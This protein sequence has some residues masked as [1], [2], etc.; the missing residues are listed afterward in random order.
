MPN[1][2]MSKI[3]ALPVSEPLEK[4]VSKWLVKFCSIFSKELTPL[5][6]ATW[7]EALSDLD[8]QVVDKACLQVARNAEFFPNP[9]TVRAALRGANAGGSAIVAEQKWRYLLEWIARHY[10]PDLGVQR[11]APP[12]EGAVDFAARAAGGFHWVANCKESDLQW[13]KKLFI[14]EF[15]RVQETSQVTH[16]LPDGSEA[17]RFLQ[18][19]A[20]NTLQFASKPLQAKS[21]TEAD[22]PEADKP[23]L[24]EVR[25]VLQNATKETPKVSAEPTQ[26]ELD[27]KWQEQKRRAKEWAEANGHTKRD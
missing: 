12:L 14:Q 20:G 13:A 26:E 16:L 17:K 18:E 4:V 10:H 22:K 11:N 15:L 19:V 5:L 25:S 8:P 6:I 2:A 3:S 7:C 9:G 23:K 21:I 24:E 27:A 1:N